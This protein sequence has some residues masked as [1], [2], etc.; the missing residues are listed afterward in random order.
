MK[1]KKIILRSLLALLILIILVVTIVPIVLYK[2]QKAIVQYVVSEMN[3]E[4]GGKLV[5][6]DSHISLFNGFPYVS[7]DLTGVKFYGTKDT[8]QRPIYAVTDLYVGFDA[9]SLLQGK[10][11]VKRISL[12][13]GHIDLVQYAN[14]DIN[15]L[16]AKG[17]KPDSTASTSSDTSKLHLKLKRVRLKDIDITYYKEADSLLAETYITDAKASFSITDDIIHARLKTGME[18]NIVQKGD[19]SFFKHKHVSIVTDLDFDQKHELLTITKGEFALEDGEFGFSGSVD[20]NDQLKTDLEI[21]GNKPDFNL[22]LSLAPPE[23]LENFKSFSNAGRVF[24]DARING[25]LAPGNKFAIDANFG[26][27]NAYFKNTISNKTVDQF[28]FLGSFNNGADSSMKTAELKLLDIAAR[29]GAGIFSGNVVIKNFEDPHINVDLHSDLDLVFLG[30]FLNMDNLKGIKGK[31][32]LDM[33]FN[34]LVDFQQPE[35]NLVKLKEGIDSELQIKDLSILL[36]GFKSPVENLNL[37]AQMKRGKLDLDTLQFR[38]GSSD[39]SMK[40][41]LDDLP[42]IFHFEDKPINVSLLAN[43]KKLKLKDFLDFDSTLANTT[44]EEI[45]DFSITLAFK[46]SVNNLTHASGIPRGEFLI[47]D[48]YAKLKNYPHTFHD[49]H[50]DLF[51]NDTTATLKD[52]TGQIDK[53]DFQF[54]GKISNYNLWLANHKKG[55][56]RFSFDFRS[57]LIK[58]EDLFSY[59]GENYVPEDYRHEEL[60]GIRLHGEMGLMYDSSLKAGRIAFNKVE[61]K[62]KL[63]PLKLEEA[64]GTFYFGRQRLGFSD[65]YARM[66]KSDLK[67]SLS[68]Y[69]G[70]NVEMKK[71]INR[72]EIQSARL[73]LDELSNFDLKRK[74]KETV[75][76]DSAFNIFSL[77]FAHL[78]LKA[79]IGELTYH[80]NTLKNVAATLRMQPDHYLYVDTFALAAAEGTLGLSGY[81]N[82]SDPKQIYFKSNLQLDHVDID[83]LLF[84]FDNFGQDYAWNENLHG[85]LTGNINSTVYMHPDLVPLLDKAEAEMNVTITDGKLVDFA[86]MQAMSKY[87]KDKNLRMIRFDTLSNVLTLKNAALSFPNMNINSSLGF[88]EISGTQSLN[89]SMDY[90]IRVPLKMVTQIGFRHLFGGKKRE[91]VDPEQED[92]IVY[93][94]EDKK[95]AF[96]NLRIAGTPDDYKI[97]LKKKKG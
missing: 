34:E 66:G 54:T 13:K 23:I 12:E 57:D 64:K 24:F 58:L 65:F 15:L 51:I 35:N 85:M 82:G 40:G 19:T 52:F 29:P 5:I 63:H 1:W 37:H 61:A 84:R 4:F 73:D 81:F 31:V 76:H 87:F 71:Q 8:T 78:A 38:L 62:M 30:E 18:V 69:T 79:D 28:G 43:A 86:P 42:A 93:R 36:P 56:T 17:I 21:H 83:K 46:T 11:D 33:R 88:I 72:I 6:D 7:I 44:D 95:L 14:G 3:K 9:K 80:H 77:P 94:D 32:M 97:S 89:T 92:A 96:V 2:K 60:S 16:L 47:D 49:F 22:L 20:I 68:L 50:A 27:E 67:A 74:E 41:A 59:N 45:S 25:R 70:D 48:F 53:S 90:Y 55:N 26:C 39:L 91:E 75:S 10:Y